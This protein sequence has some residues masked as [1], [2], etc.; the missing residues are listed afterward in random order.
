MCHTD[1]AQVTFSQNTYGT[2]A[3]LNDAED[4]AG[5]CAENAVTIIPLTQDDEKR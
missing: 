4:G 3:I 5:V 2:K 1:T